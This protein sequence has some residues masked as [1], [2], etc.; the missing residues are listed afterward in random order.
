MK[1]N[2]LS[3]IIILTMLFALVGCSESTSS[4]SN[5]SANTE[6]ISEDVIVLRYGELNPDGHVAAKTAMYFAE[7]VKEKSNGKIEIEVYPSGQLGDQKTEI[8]AV[9]MG[10]LDMFRVNASFLAESG[11]DEL[12]V[13][14]LPYIFR[15]IDHVWNVIDSP[16][17]K[18]LLGSIDSTDIKLKGIGFLP[19]NPRN[20]FFTEA[21]VTSVDDMKGLKLRVPE[22][23]IYLDTTSAFGASPT[24]I[25]Y[26]ELYSALQTGVVDGAENPLTGYDA[27]KFYEVAKFYTFDSH[28]MAPS[29]MVFSEMSWNKLS[30]ENQKIINEAWRESEEWFRELSAK[31]SVELKKSLEEKGVEFFEVTDK[32]AWIEAVAPLYEKYG[33]GLEDL[34]KRIQDI[35]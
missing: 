4:Q 18:E 31:N 28:N 17:R 33:V 7:L 14:D 34:I 24:P 6:E 32:E 30:E 16:I 20:F 11:V 8:Q 26:S 21:K 9:Q 19:E 13:L 27:N 22:S 23:E 1:K 5:E 25:A 35:N 12:K 2:I 29:L 3:L 15:G 10:A